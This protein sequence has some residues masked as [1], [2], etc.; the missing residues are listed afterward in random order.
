M[1]VSAVPCAGF[2]RLHRRPAAI[3]NAGHPAMSFLDL[4]QSGLAYVN[5]HTALDPGGAVRGQLLPVA[6]VPEPEGYA[7]LLAGLGIV[8]LIARRRR[9]AV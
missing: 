5:V 9:Q 6:V 2:V 3:L 7:M 8:G 4:L 1:G